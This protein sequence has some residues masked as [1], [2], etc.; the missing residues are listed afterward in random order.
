MISRSETNC[1]RL[2]RMAAI[3]K[4]L[5]QYDIAKDNAFLVG[6]GEPD[7]LTALAAGIRPI[8]VLWGNRT[9]EQLASVGATLFAEHPSD[10][11]AIID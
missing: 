7:V 1:H 8:A 9:K 6:D 4:S 2:R 3:E 11:L 10:L 5:Q